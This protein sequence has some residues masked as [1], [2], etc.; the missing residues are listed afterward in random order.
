MTIVEWAIVLAVKA[1]KEQVDKLGEPY[2]FHPLRLMLR[3]S[4]EAAQVIAVL[5]DVIED[6]KPHFGIMA[7]QVAQEIGEL[8]ALRAVTKRPAG[9]ETY[10]EFTR[11]ARDAGPVAREVKRLDVEDHIERALTPEL[12]GM[13]KSRYTKALRILK[14]EED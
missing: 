10:F 5:H 12:K 3:A 6:C 7:E 9:E 8:E 11:R 14:G 1:H 4:S 13:V 2:I